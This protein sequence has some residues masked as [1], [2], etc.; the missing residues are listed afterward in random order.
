MVHLCASSGRLAMHK[1]P[2]VTLCLVAA[3]AVMTVFICLS[4]AFT[5]RDTEYGSGK[6]VFKHYIVPIVSQEVTQE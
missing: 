4:G 5:P 2:V 6:A 3:L 1:L